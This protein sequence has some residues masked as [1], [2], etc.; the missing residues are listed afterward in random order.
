MV[1]QQQKYKIVLVAGEPSG[2]FLGAQ[3]M[4]A[5]KQRNPFLEFYGVGGH[6][7]SEEGLQSFFPLSDLAIM[8]IFE[9]FGQAFKVWRRLTE[10]TDFI[11]SLQPDVIVTIDF[12]GFNFRLGKRL[13]K[14]LKETPLI[15]YVAPTVWAWRRGRAKKVS[16]FLNHLLT[17][18][19]FEPPYFKKHNLPTTFVGHPVTEMDFANG[20][21]AH[22]ME[23]YNISATDTLV[24]VLPG[25]RR[26]ELNHHVKIF[27]QTIDKLKT[28][29]PSLKVVIPTLPG[30]KEHLER[31]WTSKVPTF[32]ITEVA[33]KKDA[34]AASQIAVAAS[35]TIA[36]ELAQARLPMVIAYKISRL[37]ALLVKVLV[38]VRYFCM[39]NIL[40]RR[41]V[42]P[43]LLQ[44]NC[45][46]S[47]L[48][49]EALKLIRNP[50][51]KA[52]Q[53]E[54]FQRV[55]GLLKPSQGLPSE[56]AAEVVL[57][58]LRPKTQE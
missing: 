19:P 42:V 44:K 48:T 56:K 24:T 37:N 41:Y 50:Q 11:S 20:N 36:L 26:G 55:D 45:T 43:E 40:L 3:L 18:F 23:K 57:R 53:E 8:G 46:V 39:V 13:K 54:A 5:L 2:D 47:N 49:L 17:L 29:I 4:K 22:F 52:Q 33:E 35:G 16:K 38:Q 51:K 14:R 30:I 25:S 9:S 28:Q 27:Q 34:Y 6:L 32:F 21:P 58:Y 12:P 15:H 7:M 1:S 10:V 31:Q